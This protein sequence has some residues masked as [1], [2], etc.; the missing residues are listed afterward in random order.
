M[1]TKPVFAGEF[2]ARSAFSFL[3]GANAPDELVI[4]ALE[5]GYEALAITDHGG[6]YGSARAHKRAAFLK[7]DG[8]G[9]IRMNVGATWELADGSHLPVLCVNR[10]GYQALSRGFTG[11]HLHGDSLVQPAPSGVI[12]LTGDREGPV[13]RHLLRN[14]KGAA[15]LAAEKLVA[16]FGRENVYVEIHRHGLRDEARLNRQL[17]DLAGH[18]RLR[19]LAGNAPLHADKADRLLSDAFTCLRHHMPLDGAGRLLAV[20][21]ERHLKSPAEMDALFADLPEA[22]ENTRHLRD[23]LE[24]TLE[25]LGYRFPDFPDEHGQP[26]TMA[27]QTRKLREL[28]E[29]EFGRIHPRYT[30]EG[31]NQVAREI[32]LIH[33]LGFSGYFLTVHDIVRFARSQGI[34]CQ[35]RGSA[36]NSVV[37]FTLGITSVDP[38]KNGLLFDR[39][40]V[41]DQVAWPDVDID[42][43]SGVKRESVI[44][45]VFGKYGERGAA[46]TANV[47]TY[48]PR[49]AFREMSKVLGFPESLADRFS[50]EGSSSWK[51]K[52]ATEA[53]KRE[54]FEQ[55][56]SLF[57]PPSHP[58]SG[59]LEKLYNAVLGKPRHLGQHSGGI[60]VCAGRLDAVVPIQRAAMPGRTVVQWDKDDGEDLGIVK[61]DLLGLGM[62]AAMED[63]IEICGQRGT[64]RVL[65]GMELEDPA[66]FQMMQR[67]DTIGTFQVESRAQMATLPLFRPNSY[68]DV[69]M[70]VAIIRPGP[71]VGDLVHPLIAR[72]QGLEKVDCIHD[73]CREILERTYGIALFQEQVLLMARKMAGFDSRQADKLR[74]AIAFTRDDERMQRIEVE[75]RKGMTERGH[76][77]EVQ[78]KM[79]EAISKFALYGFPESHALSF[80]YLAYASCWLKLYHPAAFYTGLI[81]HQPMGFYS[82]H[83]LMQDAKHR[84]IRFLPVSVVNS[85]VATEVVEETVIRLGLHRVKGLSGDLLP[86]I[87]R[88]REG[89]A[90]DSLEDFLGRTRP[91]DK[92]RRA[93]AKA[94]A[95]NDLPEVV[96]RR[97]A[98]WQSELPLHGDLLRQESSSPVLSPMAM[99]ERLGADMETQGASTGPHPMRLWR[100]STELRLQRARD[101]DCQ[102]DG[103]PVVVGGMVICRQRPGTAKGHCFIS[104]EDETGIANLFVPKST[105]DLFRLVIV[106]ESFLL[107]EGRVQRRGESLPTVYVTAVRS[108][109]GFDPAHGT[110]SHDFH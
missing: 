57:L 55:R 106:T 68:Y 79:A 69:A 13:C 36:A 6:F 4:R 54:D 88:A 30:I 70:Q 98:L 45:Y 59:A 8:C 91:K 9:V 102:P 86:R 93:L 51:H 107:A 101:L 61:I 25:D 31:W 94:G 96:H 42:F 48:R 100:Q 76:G 40:L 44:Q 14:D 53:E 75:L 5:L 39:F 12:A 65:D 22:L 83:T 46:M 52:P 74:R 67:A 77:E 7:G 47:I 2:H 27:D 29:A 23:R 81:N 1:R 62:L 49:S 82:V 37:C 63:M 72:R 32:D 56:T 92:E 109:P 41:E 11:F 19:L 89:R 24:F 58:R 95:L 87:V 60:I 104:L 99:A 33:R 16:A 28:A 90:F 78:E 34:L 110:T 97:H 26:M 50:N 43:P 3:R 105:Y 85:G 15:L 84:G 80:A 17:V 21:G 35:G 66:V 38:I 64:P 18:L 20:N 71:I 103:M 108:L 73:D 10:E